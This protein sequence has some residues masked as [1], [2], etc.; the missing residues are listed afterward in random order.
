MLFVTV[1]LLQ[2]WLTSIA[3]HFGRQIKLQYK[4]GQHTVIYKVLAMPNGI[5]RD[6]IVTSTFKFL[7]DFLSGNSFRG[8]TVVDAYCTIVKEKLIGKNQS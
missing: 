4:P 2:N 8:K 5:I 6:H 1:S 7:M 3:L